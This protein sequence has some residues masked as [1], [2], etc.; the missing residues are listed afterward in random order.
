MPFIDI[1]LLVI[2]SAFAIAGLAFG[3]VHTLGSLLGTIFGA[4]IASRYY[5]VFAN[6][7]IHFTGWNSNVTRVIVFIFAFL[8]ITRLVGLVFWFL[9]KIFKIVTFLPFIKSI[10]RLL[11]LLFGVLEGVI[12]I[13]L[14]IYFIERVPLSTSFMQHLADSQVAPYTTS[15]AR[16]LLPLLPDAFRLLKSTVDY[17]THVVSSHI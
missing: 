14:V 13:G 3:L 16:I 6:W 15:I 12:S 11:G 4:Y 17:I 2:I 5:D 10:D 8:I 9:E 1:V 7:I